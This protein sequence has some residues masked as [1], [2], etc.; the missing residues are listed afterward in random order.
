MVQLTVRHMVEGNNIVMELIK[1]RAHITF[2]RPKEV[3]S[4]TVFT[5]SDPSHGFN[6]SYTAIPVSSPAFVSALMP[7]WLVFLTLRL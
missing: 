3:L 2:H 7:E 4:I 5:I 1:L 6:E